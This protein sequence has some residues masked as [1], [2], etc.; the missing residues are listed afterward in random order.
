VKIRGN[1]ACSSLAL[2]LGVAW[3]MAAI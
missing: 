1:I 3:V 2:S